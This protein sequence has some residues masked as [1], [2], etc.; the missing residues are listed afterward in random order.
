MFGVTSTMA[1]IVFSVL[2]GFFSGATISL[3]PASA[4]TLSKAVHEIVSSGSQIL[5][6]LVRYAHR[7]ISGALFD[8]VTGGTSH[9]CSVRSSDDLRWSI[10]HCHSAKVVGMK[11]T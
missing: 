3:M 2:Y 11:G 7:P 4:V 5:T 1:V 10:V 8:A 6:R 9:L